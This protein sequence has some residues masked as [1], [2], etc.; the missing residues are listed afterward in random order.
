MPEDAH[1]VDLIVTLG[2]DHT[3]LQS[4]A[5]AYDCT[6]PM[7]G[8][9][10]QVAT[11]IGV[12]TGNRVNKRSA[13]QETD[14][15]LAAMDD[16]ERREFTTRTRILLEG[17]KAGPVGADGLEGPEHHIRKLCLNE[18]FIAEHDVASASRYRLIP[19]KQNLGLFKSS[20]LIVS[21]GT[22]STGWLYAARQ[23]IP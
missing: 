20:G 23:I 5:I 12:L 21:T 13:R 6:I 3:Y 17:T 19:D 14:M 18:V 1:D 11:E 9:N 7:L 16:P 15:I 22:G 2:G 8:I 4:S 10:T